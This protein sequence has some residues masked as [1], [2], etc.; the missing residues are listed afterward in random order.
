MATHLGVGL[1]LS[2]SGGL[3]MTRKSVLLAV[4]IV[5]LL[6]G[7]AG[8]AL[9]LLVRHEPDFYRRAALAPGEERRRLSNRCQSKLSDFIN[10]V[11]NPEQ[12]W[13]CEFTDE[14]LNS[15]LVEDLVRTG[16]IENTFPEGVHEPRIALDADKIRFA[17]R[18]G[19]A[20]W[21][22]IVSFE[23]TVWLPAREPNVVAMQLEG[24]RAGS[25]PIT[26]QTILD[27]F[28]EALRRKD[29]EVNW[30]RNDGKPVAL[31]RFQPGVKTPT[32]QLRTLKLE[33]GRVVLGMGVGSASSEPARANAAPPG[34]KPSAN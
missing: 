3:R 18:Y 13:S 29:I 9:V 12:A 32:V 11:I 30:Y 15:Y 23:L 10:N 21:S 17:F 26:A 19:E 25:L 8:T 33:P 14:L 28:S 22:T 2:L 31:L 1:N 4:A 16:G 6:V 7:G 27:R 24:L 20:P 5:V 34:V